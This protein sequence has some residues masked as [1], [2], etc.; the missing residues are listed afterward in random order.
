MGGGYTYIDRRVT[1][2][3]DANYKTVESEASVY[4]DISAALASARL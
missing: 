2:E 1:I 4:Y 3:M